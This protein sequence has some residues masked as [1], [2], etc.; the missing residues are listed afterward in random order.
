LKL[1]RSCLF[2]AENLIVL[3]SSAGASHEVCLWKTHTEFINLYIIL[4]AANSK[5][6]PGQ[7][8]II[9][10]VEKELSEHVNP[11]FAHLA[12]FTT[13]RENFPTVC[14]CT[15]K[16]NCNLTLISTRK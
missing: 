16:I 4:H 6:L 11:S 12:Y 14:V 13:L 10:I 15:E 2:A 9:A 8:K 3:K 5:P 7:K 1:R